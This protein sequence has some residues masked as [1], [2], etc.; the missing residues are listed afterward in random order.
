MDVR[1]SSTNSR[2]LEIYA[3]HLG[4]EYKKDKFIADHQLDRNIN[5]SYLEKSKR[6]FSTKCPSIHHNMVASTSQ[7]CKLES[8]G[9]SGGYYLSVPGIVADLGESTLSCSQRAHIIDRELKK[10]YI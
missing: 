3:T 6:P 10:M 2:K 5:L 7:Q 1:R 8:G 9:R 4:S